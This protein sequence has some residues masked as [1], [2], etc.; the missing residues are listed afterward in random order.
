MPKTPQSEN[1]RKKHAMFNIVMSMNVSV[2]RSILLRGCREGVAK[3]ADDES[4]MY[5]NL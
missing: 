2:S 4:L 3:K 1:D 5:L